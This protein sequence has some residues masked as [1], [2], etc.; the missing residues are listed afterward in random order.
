MCIGFGATLF[1]LAIALGLLFGGVN[2][3]VVMTIAKINPKLIFAWLPVEWALSAI[4]NS[5]PLAL[6]IPGFFACVA[7]D[8]QG[9][10]SAYGDLF[11]CMDKFVN[12]FIASLLSM[13]AIMVGTILCII[14]GILVSPV[15]MISLYLVWKGES[16]MDAFKKSFKILLDNKLAGLFI[17]LLN[18]SRESE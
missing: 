12:A 2:Q 6:M 14:P 8:A 16:G 11:K 15:L 7:S 1:V 17:I 13:L 3:V 9:G 5:V 4:I 18:C 10:K